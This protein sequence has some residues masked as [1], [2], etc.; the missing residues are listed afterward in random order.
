[1]NCEQIK[2]FIDKKNYKIINV[3]K[4][5]NYKFCKFGKILSCFNEEM[6]ER[7]KTSFYWIKKSYKKR[8]WFAIY[9]FSR[10]FFSYDRVINNYKKNIILE[11]CKN[12][13][14]DNKNLILFINL[15]HEI[16]KEKLPDNYINNLKTFLNFIT[17]NDSE[18][19]LRFSSHSFYALFNKNK[20]FFFANETFVIMSKNV[21]YF[22]KKSSYYHELCNIDL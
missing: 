22:Y 7:Y 19:I 3:I 5:V 17:D 21:L 10:I 1:M 2:E 14:E 6:N 13:T 12:I 16:L 11:E 8:K 4:E 15:N 18:V 9:C 20:N